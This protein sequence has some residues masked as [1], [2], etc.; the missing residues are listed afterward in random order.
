MSWQV[1][2]RAHCACADGGGFLH[3]GEC[4]PAVGLVNR[5]N[6]LFVIELHW[7]RVQF[8]GC[9][10]HPDDAFMRQVV[11]HL[12]DPVDGVLAGPRLLICDA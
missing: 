12:T 1:F 9:T 4:G 3:D 2:L 8:V 5:T 6:T 10:P 11:R 7:R